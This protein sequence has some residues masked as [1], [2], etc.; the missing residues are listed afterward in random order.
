MILERGGEV[1]KTKKKTQKRVKRRRRRRKK[2]GR[3]LDIVKTRVWPTGSGEVCGDEKFMRPLLLTW[4]P[5]FRTA[6]KATFW[7]VVVFFPFLFLKVSFPRFAPLCFFLLLLLFFFSLSFLSLLPPDLWAQKPFLP[8]PIPQ[9]TRM[10]PPP[11][12]ENKIGKKKHRNVFKE[13]KK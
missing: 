8:L 10:G 2:K 12:K 4:I 13:E 9:C 5:S 6:P 11:Q 7:V 3:I 1:N